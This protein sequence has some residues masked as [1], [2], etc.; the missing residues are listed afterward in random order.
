MHEATPSTVFQ[1][2]TPELLAA[3]E[4]NDGAGV[5]AALAGGRSGLVHARVRQGARLDGGAAVELH[6]PLLHVAVQAGADRAIV[7]LLR[8]GARLARFRGRTAFE[9]AIVR[10]D[11]ACIG[12]FTRM[13][14]SLTLSRPCVLARRWQGGQYMHDTPLSLL[15]RTCVATGTPCRGWTDALGALAH[16]RARVEVGAAISVALALVTENQGGLSWTC[17]RA[18]LAG[19]EGAAPGFRAALERGL[20]TPAELASMLAAIDLRDGRLAERP[21]ARWLARH[22]GSVVE[23]EALLAAGAAQDT[24]VVLAEWQSLQQE[25]RLMTPGPGRRSRRLA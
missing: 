1:Q 23:A 18:V 13:R 12:A 8:G 6:R 4:Q 20:G 14:R 2:P 9:S 22:C 16:Q 10:L 24:L 19:I 3:I 5:A 15:V 17:A 25:G 11:P 7:A 21:A